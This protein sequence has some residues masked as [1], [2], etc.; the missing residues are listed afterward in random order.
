MRFT[1]LPATAMSRAREAIDG[2]DVFRGQLADIAE[3]QG[4]AAGIDRVGM[5]WL[6]R[7]AGWLEE[8]RALLDSDE[9]ADRAGVDATVSSRRAERRRAAAEAAAES[10]RAEIAKLRQEATRER[11]LRERA[12]EAGEAVRRELR[13]ATADLVAAR[14]AA[15]HAADRESA[16]RAA[17]Q[18]AEAARDAA[19]ARAVAAERARDAVLA[20][21]ASAH[22]DVARATTAGDAQRD[23]AVGAVGGDA[24]AALA[25]AA[26]SARELADALERATRSVGAAAAAPTA[27]PETPAAAT[28]RRRSAGRDRRSGAVRQPVAVP[29]SALGDAVSTTEHLLRVPG[30]LVIVDGYNVAKLGWPHVSLEQQRDVCVR[31]LEDVARRWA[32]DILVVFDGADVVGGHSGR[33]LVAVRFSPPGSSADEVICEE[34]RRQPA[35][36]PL[37]VVTNDN[38]IVEAVRREGAN[39]TPS[40]A[41]LATARR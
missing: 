17:Q 8:A 29:G 36:R 12:E 37:V 15:R 2:D 26:R 21:R 5:L 27:P 10:A 19:T 33:R 1:K 16:A 20:E 13:T 18:A 31:M 24:A 34:V 6:R 39:V 30:A 3:A 7:P 35:R 4:D 28:D 11:Q 9:G 22:T 25:S 38:A 41:L 40:D 23:R 14:T 32:T